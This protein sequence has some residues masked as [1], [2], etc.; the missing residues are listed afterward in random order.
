MNPAPHD[1]HFILATFLPNKCDTALQ[2]ALHS[3]RQPHSQAATLDTKPLAKIYLG[4][5]H[6]H[7]SLTLFQ[8]ARPTVVRRSS[9]PRL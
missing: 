5:S 6:S 7:L 4:G 9:L 1:R 3:D 2:Q 8:H